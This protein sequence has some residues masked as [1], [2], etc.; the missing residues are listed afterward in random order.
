MSGPEAAP[1]PYAGITFSL[2]YLAHLRSILEMAESDAA[3]LREICQY[4]GVVMS[5]SKGWREQEIAAKLREPE[6]LAAAAKKEAQVAV[7][8]N[9]LAAYE[10][11]F[12][13]RLAAY[14]PTP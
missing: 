6:E 9:K 2:G 5:Y 13:Q 3:H 4:H 11:E 14:A 8:Q 10:A 12:D 7:M 1:D